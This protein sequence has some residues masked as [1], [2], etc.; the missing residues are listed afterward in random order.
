V[1]RTQNPKPGKVKVPGAKVSVKL[2]TAP[3]KKK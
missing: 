1:V 3:P 2:T